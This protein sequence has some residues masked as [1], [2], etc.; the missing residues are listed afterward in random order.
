M[1]AAQKHFS[2]VERLAEQW[3][4]LGHDLLP[5]LNLIEALMARGLVEL[6][7]KGSRWLWATKIY[8]AG[9]PRA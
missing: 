1:D 6:T 3:Y 7:K 9:N 4:P 8:R 2:N 5:H